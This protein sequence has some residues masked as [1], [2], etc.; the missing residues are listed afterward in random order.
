MEPWNDEIIWMFFSIFIWFVLFRRNYHMKMWRSIFFIIITWLKFPFAAGKLIHEGVLCLY[1]VSLTFFCQI[2]CVKIYG[3]CQWASEHVCLWYPKD[4]YI[5]PRV[6][7]GKY[8][9]KR[10]VHKFVYV[11][12]KP[13]SSAGSSNVL[14]LCRGSVIYCKWVVWCASFSNSLSSCEVFHVF[15]SMRLQ[16]L[17][18]SFLRSILYLH[19]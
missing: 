1:N 10:N 8:G 17:L 2:A 4:A 13:T 3:F 9:G 12:S 6:R 7:L 16:Q 14:L 18:F 11:R 15:F 5:H 19:T